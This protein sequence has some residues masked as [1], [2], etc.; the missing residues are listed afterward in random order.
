MKN[1]LWKQQK[2]KNNPIRKLNLKCCKCRKIA[3]KFSGAKPYCSNCIKTQNG[4][5]MIINKKHSKKRALIP[6][7]KIC[8]RCEKRYLTYI[9]KNQFCQNCYKGHHHEEHFGKP[10]E[11]K[12]IYNLFKNKNKKR[13]FE[14]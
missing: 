14:K 11:A 3:T 8:K 9:P 2:Q 13:I 7:Q 12:Y 6:L 1:E 10:K 4:A 5:N